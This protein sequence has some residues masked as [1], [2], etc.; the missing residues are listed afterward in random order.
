MVN[1]V[2]KKMKKK[3]QETFSCLQMDQVKHRNNTQNLV[4][5][6]NPAT[7]MKSTAVQIIQTCEHMYHFFLRIRMKVQ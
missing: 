2:K 1:E 3:Y 4:S 6:T 5:L 7:T